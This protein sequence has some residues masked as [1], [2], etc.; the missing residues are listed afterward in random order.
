MLMYVYYA[1]YYVWQPLK[2]QCADLVSSFLN[3]F[4]VRG[5]NDCQN[6]FSASEAKL[7]IELWMQMAGR[8]TLLLTNW[9]PV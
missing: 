8:E 3:L 6:D 7:M 9:R 2:Q 4:I 5:Y 1:V